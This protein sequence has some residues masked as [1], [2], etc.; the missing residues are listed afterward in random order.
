MIALSFRTRILALVFAV[1]LVPLGVLGLWLTRGTARSGEELLRD[2]LVEAREEASVRLGNEW[3]ARRSE[4]L[5]LAD[6]R[7]V[8]AE[9]RNDVVP[10][11]RPVPPSVRRWMLE[12]SGSVRRLALE[13]ARGR[14]RWVAESTPGINAV[15]A[16]DAPTISVA[17]PVHDSPL[18]P[19]IGTLVADLEPRAL[20][21]SATP[22]VAGMVL[23]AFDDEGVSLLPVPVDPEL[24]R[25]VRFELAGD[26]WLTVRR[27][28]QDPRVEL[29]AAAPLTPFIQPFEESA[30]RGAF[31]MLSVLV[32]GMFLAWLLSRRL[33]GSLEALATAAED[34][35]HGELGRRVP[36]EGSDEVGRVAAAFNSMTES[37]RETMAEL[38]DRRALA[39]VGE[40]A[41]SLAHEIRNPLTSIQVDL[42]MV[43]ER[44]TGEDSETREIQARALAGVQR[45]DGTVSGALQAARSG[46]IDHRGVD[47]L[48]PLEAA[49]SAAEATVREAGGRLELS[50][51][52]TGVAQVRGDAQAL[53]QLFL[54][55]MLNAAQAL[56][57][58]GT[59]RVRVRVQDS[60]VWVVVADDGRGIPEGEQAEVFEPFHTTRPGGTGLGLAIAR[61]LTEAHGGE[62]TMESEVGRGTTVQVRLPAL[63]ERE[64]A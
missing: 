63:E 7:G 18:G 16:A 13:D 14:T 47:I 5:D 1:G 25:E 39:A 40:F 62:I 33:T 50:P 52:D 10:S 53:E 41:A 37:L 31:L 42:Q 48:D 54:N 44:L 34:V 64:S 43:E 51:P 2:R 49:V 4:L 19:R 45:L 35:T 23:G 8:R 32:V 11:P 27:S 55:L 61:R 29:V 12:R 9:F 58:S 15:D 38:A 21:A 22:R 30:R 20:L 60:W 24:L 57:G 56:E 59:V 36:A 28:L 46:R 17:I 26:T 3:V 6:S